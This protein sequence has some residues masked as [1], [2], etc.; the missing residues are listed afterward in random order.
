MKPKQEDETIDK[1]PKRGKETK[2]HNHII[3][4]KY[5]GSGHIDK[6]QICNILEYILE[7]SL[8]QEA[9]RKLVSY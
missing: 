7:F 9:C 4:W 3:C 1:C 2:S 6:V 8:I 5:L